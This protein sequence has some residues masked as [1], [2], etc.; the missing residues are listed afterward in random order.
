ML[1][2]A[3]LLLVT[4]ALATAQGSDI[5][6]QLP[7]EMEAMFLVGSLSTDWTA[8]PGHGP[9]LQ[10][11]VEEGPNDHLFAVDATTGALTTQQPIDRDDVCKFMDRCVL[12]LG[13]GVASSLKYEIVTVSVEVLDINDNRPTF[14]HATEDIAIP[15]DSPL[16]S[17]FPLSEAFDLDAGANAQLT[18]NLT[19]DDREQTSRFRLRT[20]R[21]LDAS[22]SVLLV[23]AQSLDRERQDSYT[24]TL[25]AHDNGDNIKLTSSAIINVTVS[26][27]NDNVATFTQEEYVFNVAEDVSPNQVIGSVHADDP[28]AGAAGRVTYRFLARTEDLYGDVFAISDRGEVRL[29]TSLDFETQTSYEL[30]V[31]ASDSAANARSSNAKISV[32]VIDVNDFAPQISITTPPNTDQPQVSENAPADTLIAHVSVV[33]RD[34]G[35]SGDVECDLDSSSFRLQ[36]EASQTEVTQ[37]KLVTATSFDRES[38]DVQRVTITCHDLGSASLGSARDVTVEILD[39]NDHAPTFNKSLYSVSLRETD[40]VGV[41]ITTVQADDRDAGAN[42]EL[43]FSIVEPAYSSKFHVDRNG[44]ITSLQPLDHEIQPN[45]DFHVRAQDGGQPEARSAETRVR[46]ELVDI[47]DSPPT[48]AQTIFD[49]SVEE[50]K[51][52]LTSLGALEASDRDQSPYNSFR[53]AFKQETYA[54]SAYFR[55]DAD[56]GELQTNRPLDRETR[57]Q[58]TFDVIVVDRDKPTLSST[59]TVRVTVEDVNDVTPHFLF[60]S[61]SNHTVYVPRDLAAGAF[62]TQV[63]AD[64]S[65]SG[66]N[67]RLTYDV[68]RDAD[69]A[70]DA[71]FSISRHTGS[72]TALRDLSRSDWSTFNVSIEVKDSGTPQLSN[73]TWIVVMATSASAQKQDSASQQNMVILVCLVSVSAV[74]VVLLMIGICFVLHKSRFRKRKRKYCRGDEDG[75][76]LG[77]KVEIIDRLDALTSH[78]DLNSSFRDGRSYDQHKVCSSMCL[79]KACI[80]IRGLATFPTRH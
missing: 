23:V 78:G 51:P 34:S 79:C 62:V 22:D 46:V 66:V 26:D 70:D 65:D 77:G 72:I 33:D 3:H 45:L 15:E 9:E 63:R 11:S 43:S 14:R 13:V 37:Y 69:A 42:A 58:F 67:A 60:P 31:S 30:L 61:P 35:A 64:D 44:L 48:F 24:L 80:E 29:L 54:I 27:V 1:T 50:N 2:L 17:T 21:N 74:V 4:S 47:N 8:S 76:Q 56:T 39:E 20:E 16:N 38:S 25:V 5:Q 10:Y 40:A 18:Y 71:F 57:D 6:F 75:E 36:A 55:L 19:A 53:F 73:R 32:N 52:E 68:I 7:E 59:A 41:Y 49:F 12:T 28:D